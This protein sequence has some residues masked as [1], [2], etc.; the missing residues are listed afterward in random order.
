MKTK[1]IFTFFTY[2]LYPLLFLTLKPP[3]ASSEKEKW[4]SQNDQC[5]LKRKLWWKVVKTVPDVEN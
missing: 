3:K 4:L 1:L 5:F 2:G